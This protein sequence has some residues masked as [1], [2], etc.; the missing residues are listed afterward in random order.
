MKGYK[1]SDMKFEVKKEGSRWYVT[2]ESDSEVKCSGRS[3]IEALK[4]LPGV[5]EHLERKRG[6]TGQM[7][8]HHDHLW[9][10]CKQLPQD[11][12]PYGQVDR[13]NNKDCSCG[14]SYFYKLESKSK[15]RLYLDWGVCGNPKSHRCGLMTFEHQG[16]PHAMTEHHKRVYGTNPYAE[17][18]DP[19]NE[20]DQQ[21][22]SSETERSDRAEDSHETTGFPAAK[23]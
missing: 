6:R 14:C 19:E 21:I 13:D 10:I 18:V 20:P 1:G 7:T 3:M 8:K 12:K 11:Y 5:L 15:E 17:P 16:C 9:S 23:S 22:P 4:N 2:S